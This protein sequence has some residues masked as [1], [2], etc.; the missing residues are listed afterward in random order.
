MFRFSHH[1]PLAKQE[2][3]RVVG[4]RRSKL[5]NEMLASDA[6]NITCRCLMNVKYPQEVMLVLGDNGHRLRW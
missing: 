5:Y 3:R 6:S 2:G 4:V 1:T